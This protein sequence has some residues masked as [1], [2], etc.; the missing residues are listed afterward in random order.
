MKYSIIPLAIGLAAV[1]QSC[2]QSQEKTHQDT[3]MGQENSIPINTS[4]VGDITQD[5][6]ILKTDWDSVARHK[7]MRKQDTIILNNPNFKRIQ[8]EIAADSLG[9]IRINQIIKPDGSSDGPFGRELDYEVKTPGPYK[10]IIGESKMQGDPFS[11]DY[12]LMFKAQ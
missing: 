9:N 12:V 6:L 10:L 3:V 7:I 8:A 4:P 2:N 5:S 1:I 11:G